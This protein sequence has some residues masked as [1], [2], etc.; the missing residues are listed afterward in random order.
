MV[1]VGDTSGMYFVAGSPIRVGKRLS[2]TVRGLQNG[3][4]YFFA[5][6]AYDGAGEER[7][8]QLSAEAWA[9][10][11]PHLGTADIPSQGG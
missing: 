11:L 7:I 2:Y 3:V 5:L 9:R 10:P 4:L 1:Y 6:A 8:G